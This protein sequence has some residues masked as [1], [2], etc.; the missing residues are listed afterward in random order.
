MRT[1]GAAVIVSC[2]LGTLP[3]AA[4]PSCPI[5]APEWP[6]PTNKT[7]EPLK[8]RLVWVDVDGSAKIPFDHA[9]RELATL[10]DEARIE[11]EWQAAKAGEEM[12][13]ADLHVIVLETS[14]G[15]S[16]KV[17]G[18]ARR[19]EA[20]PHTVRVFLGHVRRALGFHGR[21]DNSLRLAERVRLGR[22][23]GRVIAHEIVHAYAPEHEHEA[24]GLMRATLDDK[25]LLQEQVHLEPASVKAVVGG[26]SG[27]S[28]G[29][30]VLAP[31]G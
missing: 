13:S 17:M 20:P 2:T 14:P 16:V 24:E 7:I 1:W 18:A 8:L 30:A 26:L 6:A 29:T 12:T 4:E 31:E 5:R 9:A 22:A 10:F 19:S 11:I 3:A 21:S 25:F 27:G 28:M 23:I 15:V